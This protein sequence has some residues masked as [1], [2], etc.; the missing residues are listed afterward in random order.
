MFQ[1]KKKTIHCIRHAE[2]EHNIPPWNVKL[3]DPYLTTSGRSQAECLGE[4]FPFLHSIDLI[5]CSPMKRALQTTLLTLQDLL[6][7][8]KQQIIALP[9]LQ[10]LSSKPCDTGSSLAEILTE[11]RHDP[12]DLSRVPHDWESKDR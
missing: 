4:Q 2:S 7:N 1:R 10:E 5:V 3:K 8:T 6:R 9:E 12:V 11:F